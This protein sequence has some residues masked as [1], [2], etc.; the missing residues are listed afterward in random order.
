MSGFCAKP[1]SGIHYAAVGK[2][3]VERQTARNTVARGKY[4]RSEYDPWIS[5]RHLLSTEGATEP[6]VA[7]SELSCC[8][9]SPG[10]PRFALTPGYLLR[11]LRARFISAYGLVYVNLR[12]RY[13]GLWVRLSRAYGL[14]Y[15]GYGLVLSRA[16]GLV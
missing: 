14:V 7:L 16:Y 10:V 6:C 2:F 5:K 12:A 1:R 9:G 15:L 11:A 8:S 4:E 3:L 13:F